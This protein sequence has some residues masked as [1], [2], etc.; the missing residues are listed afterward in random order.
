MKFAKQISP[1]L[2][3]KHFCLGS[4]NSL[5][6]E[7]VLHRK[8][9]LKICFLLSIHSPHRASNPGPGRQ[10]LHQVSFSFSVH[11]YLFSY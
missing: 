7:T 8:F 11:I 3:L 6:R 5:V 1:L 4:H 9:R 2:N 10:D